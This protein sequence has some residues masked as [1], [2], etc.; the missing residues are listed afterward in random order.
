LNNV[1]RSKGLHHSSLDTKLVL[2]IT[3][4]LLA[5]GT[6]VVLACEYSNP[7]T[8]GNLPLP[9]KILNSFFQS[10]TSRSSGFNTLNIGSLTIFT[11]FF[12]MVLMVIGAASGSTAGGIKVNTIGLITATIWSTVRGREHPRAFGR[13][14]PLDQIFRGMTLLVLSA[15]VIMV[16]FLILSITESFHSINI[17]FET[18]SAFGT[19]GL[20]TGIT[21][22]LS[23]TGKAVL[24]VVMFMGRLGPLTLIMSL[25]RNKQISKYRYPVDTI[26]I[27]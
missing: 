15:G 14:I 26:R 21:P 23:V 22:E 20:T 19:V 2:L 12:T 8:L 13:E 11:L 9:L 7:E 1:Y 17:L 27:G 10:V 24:I 5:S 3:L 16:T 25:A 18:A 6:L 4:I